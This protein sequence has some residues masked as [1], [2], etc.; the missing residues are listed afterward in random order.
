MVKGI[1]CLGI[2]LGAGPGLEKLLL[3]QLFQQRRSLLANKAQNKL[4]K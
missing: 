1:A 4:N 3:L 2:G